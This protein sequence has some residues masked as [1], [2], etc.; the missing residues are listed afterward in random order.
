MQLT[1]LLD[2]EGQVKRDLADLGLH[3]N[4]LEDVKRLIEEKKGLVIIAAPP[5]NGRTT[6]MYAIIRTHD[7]YTSNVQTVEVDPQASMEGVRH[8]RFD[9]KVDGAEYST[10]VRSILRRDPDVVGVAEVPDDNT[11]KEVAKADYDRTRVYMCIP[12]DGALG[13]LQAYAKAVGDQKAAA[14]GLTGIIAERLARRLCENCRVEFQPTPDVLKKLGLPADTKKL[15]RKGGQ[16]M[17]KD[18]PVTCPVCNGTGFFGQVGV[19]EVYTFTQAERDQFAQNDL[20]SLK[21]S[22]RQRKQQSIQQSALMHAIAG[23]TSVEEVVRV[24]QP[25]AAPSKASGG[26]GGPGAS[27]P[28]ETPVAPPPAMGAKPA[29]SAKPP[30]KPAAAPKPAQPKP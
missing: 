2:P 20:T 7:A 22:F 27:A 4:Q 12:A 11:A 28:G 5:D 21:A 10:T 29:A 16:V 17:I 1:L 15:F 14:R 8:N 19:F 9:P 6:T 18:K 26:P 23:T 30:A 13:A 3:P 24:T 25:P